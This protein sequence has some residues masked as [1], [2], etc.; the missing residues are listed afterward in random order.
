MNQSDPPAAL[1]PGAT[2]GVFG[3]GQLGRMFGV[4]AR[5]LGYRFAVFSDDVDGPAAQVADWSVVGAYDDE[6]A[7]ANFAQ[8]VDAVTFEFENVPAIAG[9]TAARHV[10]VRP[11]GSLLH[12]VQDRLR[13]KLGLSGLGLAV[14]PFASIKD[15]AELAAAAVQIPG[16]G[17]LKTSSFGYDGK[18]QVRVASAADLPAAWE[19]LGRVPAV[20]E[21]LVPFTEEVS[22]VAARGVGG[23]VSIYEPFSNA[24]VNHILDVTACPA[25]LDPGAKAEIERIA[26]AALEGF[27]VVGV[28]CIELFML[29]GGG[30]LVNEIAPRPHNSGH[31]TVDAHVCSQFENQVRAVAGLPLGSGARTGPPAAMA[32]L[33]GDL[34]EEGE[35]DWAAA[36]SM[37]GVSLHLYGKAAARPGRKMGHITA[38]GETVEEAVQRVR[39]AREALLQPSA[40][41]LP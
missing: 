14:A 36:L 37:P 12:T 10:P 25:R 16:P 29:P 2:L 13:E 3:G 41:S 38:T 39:T 18:G 22:V 20:L 34:W 33:L 8:R 24:H 28:L 32:N 31:L 30:I 21:E 15:E 26:H 17:V 23:E 4:A 11:D 6:E 19:S 40:A 7:V 9:K 1:L 27:D 5:Q 35:P